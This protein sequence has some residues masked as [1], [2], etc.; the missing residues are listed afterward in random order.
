MDILNGR[1]G[2]SLALL[3]MGKYSLLL[4]LSLYPDMFPNSSK[5]LRISGVDIIGLVTNS[6]KSSA[7]SVGYL[8]F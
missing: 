2:Y 5:I 3:L 7:Y 8:V 1:F 6:N 4:K